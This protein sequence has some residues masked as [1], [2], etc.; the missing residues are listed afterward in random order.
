MSTAKKRPLNE[1]FSV[2]LTGDFLTKIW[3]PLVDVH[4]GLSASD[5]VK[6]AFLLLRLTQ[7]TDVFWEEDGKKV[8]A[9]DFL[10]GEHSGNLGVYELRSI[11]AMYLK[12]SN[13]EA[14]KTIS[15]RLQNPFIMDVCKPIADAYPHDSASDLIRRAVLLLQLS[16]IRE[17]F[18]EEDGQK[19]P[20]M[21]FLLSKYPEP[22]F[23]PSSA[24]LKTLRFF[25][26]E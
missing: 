4:C 16:Q 9:V 7:L 11:A 15:V 3:Q 6:R 2:R 14:S 8:L 13:G 26:P 5:I 25:S 20:A 24:S 21:D 12:K 10:W 17:L 18:L 23:A 19:V 1:L 22:S